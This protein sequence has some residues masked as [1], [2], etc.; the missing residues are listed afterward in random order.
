MRLADIAIA[1]QLSLLRFPKSSGEPLTGK[2]YPGFS[3]QPEFQV[4]VQL[5]GSNRDDPNGI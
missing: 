3:D 4:L 1:V 2:G 5:E